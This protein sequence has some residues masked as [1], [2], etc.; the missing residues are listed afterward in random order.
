MPDPISNSVPPTTPH[1]DLEPVV[2][3]AKAHSAPELTAADMSDLALKCSAKMDGVALVAVGAASASIPVIALGG[4]K[5]GMEL[6]QCLAEEIN[7]REAGA[8]IQRAIEECH[9]NGG[10][11]IG[12]LPGELTCAVPVTR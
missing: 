11:P 7:D 1:I 2:V 9:E 8:S 6:G 4:V 12:L 10:V 3:T 5:A